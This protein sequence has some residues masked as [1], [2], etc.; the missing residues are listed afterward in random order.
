MKMFEPDAHPAPALVVYMALHVDEA[1][2]NGIDDA[3]DPDSLSVERHLGIIGMF[4]YRPAVRTLP[5]IAGCIEATIL[6]R[7]V[8]VDDGGEVQSAPRKTRVSGKFRFFIH[9]HTDNAL[10]IAKDRRWRGYP[11]GIDVILNV[12]GISP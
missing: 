12:H 4:P 8:V 7:D 5:D 3:V 10:S 1:S 2:E 6:D 9:R 11:E